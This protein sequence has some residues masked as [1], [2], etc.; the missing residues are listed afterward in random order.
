LDAEAL[1]Q[2]LVTCTVYVP[3]EKLPQ[4]WVVLLG[5]MQLTPVPTTVKVTLPPVLSLKT[6]NSTGVGL[7]I[8][9]RYTSC[10]PVTNVVAVAELLLGI[11]SV[12]PVT[13]TLAVLEILP[14]VDELT[15]TPT[16]MGKLA[17]LTIGPKLQVITPAAWLQVGEPGITDRKVTPECS[18]SVTIT[19]VAVEGPVLVTRKV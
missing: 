14:V 3:G 8:R 6:D 1:P 2:L 16:V 17:F 13:V 10:S 12:L 11:G 19:L 15:L 18:V 4:N 9:G 7:S 5:T